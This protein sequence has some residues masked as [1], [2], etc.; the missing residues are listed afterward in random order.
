MEYAGISIVSKGLIRKPAVS[1]SDGFQYQDTLDDRPVSANA[2]RG[3]AY[4]ESI[5]SIFMQDERSHNPE[6]DLI[7]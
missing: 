4:P 6:I 3:V 5:S 2:Q 1:S 7:E